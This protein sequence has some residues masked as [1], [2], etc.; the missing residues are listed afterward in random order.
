MDSKQKAMTRLS[1]IAAT[2]GVSLDSIFKYGSKN[3]KPEKRNKEVQ[4]KKILN[5]KIKR[6]KKAMIRDGCSKEEIKRAIDI[7]EIEHNEQNNSNC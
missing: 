1:M 4:D 3:S 5:A 2:C 6:V 7:I